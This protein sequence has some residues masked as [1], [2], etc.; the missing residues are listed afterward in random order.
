LKARLE[1]W[2][3]ER[4]AQRLEKLQEM[5][6]LD[7]GW[8]TRYPGE[9]SGGQQQRVGLARAMML[10]PPL[11]LLDEPFAA[12]DPLTRLEIHDQ[13]QRLQS[14]EPRCILL[15]THD[16]REAMKLGDRLL[17]LEGGRILLNTDADAL[18]TGF[19]EMDPDRLLLRL[20]ERA[21]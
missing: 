14:I 17:V 5:L 19:P 21:A 2:P 18:R 11:L 10:D 1:R 9:L 4:C 20:L 12:L 6:Q 8:L 7:S 16:M 3:A 15:V 13:L